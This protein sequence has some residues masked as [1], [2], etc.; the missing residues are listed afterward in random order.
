VLCA[1]VGLVEIKYERDSENPDHDH[2]P[3]LMFINGSDH[4]SKIGVLNVEAAKLSRKC[5]GT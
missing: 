1:E 3:A 5:G 4:D 2:Q